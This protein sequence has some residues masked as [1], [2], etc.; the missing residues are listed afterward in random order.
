MFNASPF[1]FNKRFAPLRSFG[2]DGTCDHIYFWEKHPWKGWS[3][4][5]FWKDYC[6]LILHVKYAVSERQWEIFYISIIC[7]WLCT[8]IKIQTELKWS[9]EGSLHGTCTS[10]VICVGCLCAY[11]CIY[12]FVCLIFSCHRSPY[13]IAN[14]LPRPRID[15]KWA[16]MLSWFPVNHMTETTWSDLL[17]LQQ[18]Q[19]KMGRYRWETLTVLFPLLFGIC[20][21]I[22][23]I[24][25]DTLIHDY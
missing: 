25:L 20:F 9:T 16:C 14:M 1:P 4:G 21:H 24:L 11:V 6:N 13:F 17:P 10:R 8:K 12:G 15:I 22:S 23:Q 18:F 19:V 3:V 7:I 2:N 5:W